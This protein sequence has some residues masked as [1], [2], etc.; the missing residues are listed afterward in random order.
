MVTC[1]NHIFDNF[2]SNVCSSTVNYLLC[3][4]QATLSVC[5]TS[6]GIELNE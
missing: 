1:Y 6:E 3:V 4:M 2:T 5:G